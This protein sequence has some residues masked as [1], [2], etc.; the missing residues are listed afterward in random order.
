MSKTIV[1]ALGCILL[2]IISHQSVSQDVRVSLGPDQIASNQL[3]PLTITIENDRLKNY[4]PF[5]EIEGMVKRGTSS[6]TS[7]SFVNGR[8]TSSQS[9][10]QNYQPI[11][12]G[13][14]SI[15]DFT[16]TINGEDYRILGKNITIG[17]AAQQQRRTDPFDPFQDLFGERKEPTEFVDVKA[18]AFLSLTTDKED[19]YL[20]EGFTAT[21]AFYV[22]AA[23]R[24]DMR[25]YDLGNQLTE[26]L[27]DIKPTNC[28]E[29]NFNIDNVNGEPV[30]LNGKPYTQYK[31]FQ[32]TY[33]PLN[34]ETIRF[35]AVG[36]KLIKYKLAKNPS[37][38]GQNRQEDFETFTSKPKSVR[39]KPL[40]PHPLRDKVA[41]GDFRLQETLSSNTLQTAQSFNYVFNIIGEGNISSVEAPLIPEN[42]VFDFY[43]PNVT[44]NVRRS[45]N[46]VRG[47]KT[48]EYY[49]IPNEP[50]DY[51]L[52]DYAF[53]V[54]F[55]TS[56]NKY[57][58][59]RSREKVHVSGES[60]KNEYISAND[61]GS[62]YDGIDFRDN[63][64]TSIKEQKWVKILA[65]LLIFAVLGVTAFLVYKK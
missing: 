52:G 33:Y 43:A 48:F 30:Q 7:T 53:W 61:L 27:K 20:G 63:T 16:M 65:N 55:N 51:N 35:P 64:L 38:F 6:S 19:V 32:A 23:N 24:A 45:S 18:E 10:T 62:F 47:S 11:Q 15:P 56:K 46:V 31:I 3:W 1:T 26:I 25:F 8:M 4:S 49:A 37:F 29:E 40:P 58:T 21:L 57:D 14:V 22:S 41:V 28:W 2:L 13:N 9:I 12:E 34:Q 60:R 42:D 39:V 5:P 36:L 50:G 44:Q 59:L 17:P 54:F